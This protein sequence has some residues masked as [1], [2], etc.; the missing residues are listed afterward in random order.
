M[1]SVSRSL[2]FVL[3]FALALLFTLAISPPSEAKAI[4][5]VILQLPWTHQFEF[6]GFYAAQEKGF[7]AQ[8]GL[9]VEI[10]P[11]KLNR[12]P[13]SEVLSGNADFG[14]AGSEL[15]L[16]RASG[17]PV[18]AMGVIFQHSASAMVTLTDTGIYTPQDFIGQHLEMGDLT[19]DAESYAMLQAEGV[20][21]RQYEQVPSSFSLQRLINKDVSAV[22]VFV[23]NQPF[24]LKEQNIPYRLILPRSYGIDFYGDTL[25]T[26]EKLAEENP[27]LV[28]AFYRAAFKG[29]RYAFDHPDE[30]IDI[31]LEKYSDLPFAHDRKHLEFEYKE[32]EK[33]VLPNLVEIGHMNIARWHHMAKTFVSLGLL[34][35]DYS[36]EGFL[37]SPEKPQPYIQRHNFQIFG[38]ALFCA[39]LIGLL[40][41]SFNRRL[42]YQ[43][44]QN[45]QLTKEREELEK[46]VDLILWSG[47][48]G[49]WHWNRSKNVLYLNEKAA[50]ALGGQH[51]AGLFTLHEIQTDESLIS[52]RHFFSWFSEDIRKQTGRFELEQEQ[53]DDQGQTCWLTCRGEVLDLMPDGSIKTSHGILLDDTELHRAH[54]QI[55]QL[56]IT[57]AMTGLLNLRYF[58]G[59][60]E[61][62]IQRAKLGEGYFA[63]ALVDI[64]R[65]DMIKNEYGSYTA[66][67]VI[68][69]LSDIIQQQARPMDL[70]ARYTDTS[71][72]VLLP[73]TT[74]EE[75]QSACDRMRKHIA[76]Y[77]FDTSSH[78][79]FATVT[80]GIVETQEFSSTDLSSKQ[81]LHTAEERVKTGK[82]KGCNVLI[83]RNN[84]TLTSI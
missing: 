33:L 79:F 62:F 2:I 21:P 34:Q 55:E 16:A 36:L 51:E 53:L 46:K 52:V 12:A 74:A 20:T 68:E 47:H 59:R 71:F 19:S 39:C 11:G 50:A 76:H 73:G 3:P 29:W 24:Y 17:K 42:Q 27:E 54:Q 66:D 72:A 83:T 15:L 8:Q 4:Q 44:N 75:A 49:Y 23:T 78:N 10:R 6:A 41:L 26:R 30:V 5:K 64:D 37:W 13:L 25:F 77:R 35:P 63:I 14:V 1:R 69:A 28:E 9:D 82:L 81:L 84:Q 67:Y 22:S 70:I 58:M 48:L 31:I 43:I 57:D 61:A 40:L 38:I 80:I 18:I 32:M 60:L 65:M 56:T 45:K 7:F